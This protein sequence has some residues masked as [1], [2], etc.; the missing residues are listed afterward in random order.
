MTN[1]VLG[2]NSSLV[3]TTKKKRGKGK[4]FLPIRTE[5]TAVTYRGFVFSCS[6]KTH[7]KCLSC[8]DVGVQTVVIEECW[9]LRLQAS[10]SFTQLIRMIIAVIY[11]TS[12]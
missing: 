7:F 5:C 10:I 9:K 11:L 6:V 2:V 12:N 8:K 3:I 1:A 4:L